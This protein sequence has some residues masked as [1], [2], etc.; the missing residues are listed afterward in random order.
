MVA[1]SDRMSVATSSCPVP[2][3]RKERP[4]EKSVS[5]RF[6]VISD[7]MPV[8][9]EFQPS[10]RFLVLDTARMKSYTL[11]SASATSMSSGLIDHS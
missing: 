3:E 2:R 10:E 5:L 6:S 8:F 1:L 4:S 9:S 7:G 11:S